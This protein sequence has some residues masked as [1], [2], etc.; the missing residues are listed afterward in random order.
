MRDRS[1]EVAR[2]RSEIG[3]RIALGAARARVIRMVLGEVGRMVAVG[4]ALGAL[5]ALAAT[6]V[7]AS[8]LYGV[9]P[10]DPTTIALS[11]LALVAAA[12]AAGALPAWR[13][14]R[15]DPVGA[16]REE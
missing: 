4:L 10:T 8:F 11:T 2:R 9:T 5:G 1:C 7:V 6:R 12:A 14:A 3:I 15:T 13:A 16:L